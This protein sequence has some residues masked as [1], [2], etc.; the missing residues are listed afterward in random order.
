MSVLITQKSW[1]IVIARAMPEAISNQPKL[2]LLR[3]AA[4]RNDMIA[5]PA[6]GPE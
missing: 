6:C 4:P 2:S 1:K 3:R 5:P